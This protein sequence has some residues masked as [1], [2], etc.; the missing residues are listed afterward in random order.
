MEECPLEAIRES[1]GVCV[2]DGESCVDC[3]CC[4]DRCPMDAITGSR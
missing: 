3:G 1:D 2:I 4:A